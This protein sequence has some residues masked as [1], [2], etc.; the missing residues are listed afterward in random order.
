MATRQ[1]VLLV[2]PDAEGAERILALVQSAGRAANVEVDRAF[3]NSKSIQQKVSQASL[4]IADLTN[5]NPDVMYE[6]GIARAERKPTIVI[7]NGIRSLP[8]AAIRDSLFL[9]YKSGEANEGFSA[10]L[11]EWLPK[12]AKGV[13]SPA[14]RSLAKQ[15]AQQH[16]VFV[17]YCHA[18]REF[19]DRLLVHLKPL[20][21]EGKLDV[22]ADTRLRAGDKWKQE[23]ES[24]LSKATVAVL[25]VSADFMASDFIAN[26][27]LP[28]LLRSAEERGTRILPLIVR[29]SRF[30]RDGSLN[31]FQ[32]VNDPKIPLGTLTPAEQE[33][34]YDSLAE[35]V[36]SWASAG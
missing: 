23:I 20:Q 21:R 1:K 32:A 5:A 14:A 30:T 31:H 33:A 34:V 36:E 4:V 26:N 22:W 35:Q 2:Q 18:D 19:L 10:R 28:P 7:G 29:A 12:L 9:S 11:A 8:T 25:I 16:Q 15:K 24:A 3:P 13:D 27:E 17:S 6:L